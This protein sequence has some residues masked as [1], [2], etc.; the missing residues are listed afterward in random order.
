MPRDKNY[1][2]NNLGTYL[3]GKVRNNGLLSIRQNEYEGKYHHC[4]SPL[5]SPSK[6]KGILCLPFL[7]GKCTYIKGCRKHHPSQGDIPRLLAMYKKTRCRF[8]D[9]CYTDGCLFLHP[10]EERQIQEPSFI[11]LHHFPPLSNTCKTASRS[12]PKNSN[13]SKNN[14]KE[15][16]NS[17]W[18][19]NPSNMTTD[20]D[21][22]N[23]PKNKSSTNH[24][25]EPPL[26]PEKQQLKQ[27]RTFKVH[28]SQASIGDPSLTISNTRM[29]QLYLPLPPLSPSQQG[30]YG[31][32]PPT[33]MSIPLKMVPNMVPSAIESNIGYPMD[34]SL[35]Y[36]D[37]HLFYDHQ[38]L[39]EQHTG[40]LHTYADMDN[41]SSPTMNVPFNA[42]AK[43]FIPRMFAA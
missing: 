28:T 24:L 3:Q 32:P 37:Q 20:M 10:K 38:Q 7:A 1:V 42:E 17:A 19:K 9:E 31:V 14:V 29:Q 13:N 25:R 23:I 6:S 27:K 4:E 18:K 15:A 35:Y 39:Y 33:P 16:T 21:S 30:C 40:Y 36:Y 12:S 22:K 26:R 43:E 8:R 11:A 5:R 34:P 2:N 41:S